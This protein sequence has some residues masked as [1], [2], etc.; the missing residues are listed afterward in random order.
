MMR[1]PFVLL[2]EVAIGT[3]AFAVAI[4]VGFGLIGTWR[5]LGAPVAPVLRNL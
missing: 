5:A 2:P 1:S 4:T 3:A